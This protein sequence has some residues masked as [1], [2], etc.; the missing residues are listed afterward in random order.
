MPVHEVLKFLF[1]LFVNYHT[2]QLDKDKTK[3]KEHEGMKYYCLMLTENN[4]H[5]PLHFG[6]PPR[7][8]TDRS[9]RKVKSFLGEGVLKQNF[10]PKLFGFF[11]GAVLGIVLACVVQ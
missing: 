8:C 1:S 11:C 6:F 3:K 4:Y 2:S 7:I 10:G 5:T 9:K